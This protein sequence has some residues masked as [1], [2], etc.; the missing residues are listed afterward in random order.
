MNNK[1]IGTFMEAK[2]KD[3]SASLFVRN[4]QLGLFGCLTSLVVSGFNGDLFTIIIPWGFLH[5]FTASTWIVIISNMAG[6]YLVALIL[7]HLGNMVKAFAAGTAVVAVVLGSWIFFDAQLSL[8]FVIG[9]TSVLFGNGLYTYANSQNSKTNVTASTSPTRKH[10][11]NGHTN[12][13]SANNSAENE[14]LIGVT[15]SQSSSDHGD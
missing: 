7:K 15:I 10:G 14:R 2:L 5:G 4:I 8:F 13:G 3:R 6:G 9:A 11:P 1:H 12:T